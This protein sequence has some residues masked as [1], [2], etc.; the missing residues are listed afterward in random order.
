MPFSLSEEDNKD[1]EEDD[2]DQKD[3][4][5]QPTIGGNW[6]EVFKDL[7]V[8]GFYVELGVLNISVN[9]VKFKDTK[10]KNLKYIQVSIFFLCLGFIFTAAT[11]GRSPPAPWPC[12]Q[13]A[14]I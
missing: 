13:A 5:H 11:S 12:V 6:L 9:P 7:C 14:G 10:K 3:L 2:E 8:C 1:D 4:D